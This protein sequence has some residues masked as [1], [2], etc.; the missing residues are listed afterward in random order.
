MVERFKCLKP[1]VSYEFQLPNSNGPV[2]NFAH[3]Q[4]LDETTTK[5]V[6]GLTS[7]DLIELLITRTRAVNT[8]LNE[9]VENNAAIRDL[10]SA[11]FAFRA[12]QQRIGTRHIFVRSVRGLD[13]DQLNRI[14]EAAG[15]KTA[16][17]L[18][19][20]LRIQAFGAYTD[21]ELANVI[22][23]FQKLGFKYMPINSGAEVHA[24]AIDGIIDNEKL[25]EYAAK[26]GA[27]LEGI[28]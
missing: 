4:N 15:A 23:T 20:Q 26:L 7:E 2:L 21:L 25:N 8:G 6:P 17:H 28:K 19:T 5:L 12:R 9:C 22:Y 3:F 16:T 11:L 24:D 27:A 18:G 1:G 14:L 10:Q 13:A